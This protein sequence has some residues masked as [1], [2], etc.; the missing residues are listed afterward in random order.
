M[1]CFLNELISYLEERW[2]D[3]KAFERDFPSNGYWGYPEMLS[4]ALAYRRVGHQEKFSDAMTR[5]R[6][7]HDSLASQGLNYKSFWL[8]EAA[9]YAM[10]ND[11]A[12]ALEFLAA[13]IDGGHITSGRISDDMPYFKDLEGISEYEAI[14]S[15]MIEHL[16]RERALLGLEP[17]ST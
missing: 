7:A 16:N 6:K 9:Y 8:N 3:L 15:R 12:K 5:L 1:S 2:P 11:H 4:I 10:A 13:A 17:R 14:Q